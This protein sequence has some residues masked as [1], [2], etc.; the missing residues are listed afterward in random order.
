VIDRTEG[1][2]EMDG[3]EDV[4]VPSLDGLLIGEANEG[5][6]GEV[7]DE[8]RAEVADEVGEREGLADVLDV[9]TQ[10]GLE[11]EL[12]EEGGIGVWREGD[13]GDLGTEIEE[14][15]AEPRA[16]EAGVAGDEDA[17]AAEDSAEGVGMG[18]GHEEFTRLSRGRCLF[19][20][21]C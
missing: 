20:R 9:M 10:A 19:P 16:L 11:V 7:E 4:G 13:A 5:L 12:L 14:P 17:A 6:G 8:F 1:L 3:A 21:G 15:L 18:G 2:E